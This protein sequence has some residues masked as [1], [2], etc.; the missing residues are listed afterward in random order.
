VRDYDVVV[1]H[2]LAISDMLSDGI[3]RQLPAEIEQGR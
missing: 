2:I 3:A 1:G